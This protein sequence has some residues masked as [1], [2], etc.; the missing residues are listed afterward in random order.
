MT[1][2][3]IEVNEAYRHLFETETRFNVIYGGAGSGKSWAIAQMIILSMLQGNPVRKWLVCRKVGQTIRLSVWPQLLAIIN[4]LGL[5]KLFAYNKTD[6]TITGPGGGE[7]LCVGLDDV[8]KLKSILGVT[9][10]WVE[11]ASE[12][13]PADFEEL[14]TR[15]RGDRPANYRKKIFLSFNPINKTHWIKSYFFDREYPDCYILKTTYKD[16]AFLT[17]DDKQALLKYKETNPY[18]Y[19]VYALGEW[20][21]IGN[22]IFSNYREWAF[23][24]PPGEMLWG[25]DFGF[26]HPS[27]I[28]GCKYHDG[29]LWICREFCRTGLT[30]S[31]LVQSAESMKIDGTII[32]DAAEPDRIEEF[33]RS[34][35]DCRQAAKGQ[36]SLV[37][38]IDWLQSVRINI[39]SSCPNTMSEI[40]GYK[41]LEDKD[42]KSI[43]KPIP[44]ND[45]CLA[46]IRYAVEPVRLAA[47]PAEAMENPWR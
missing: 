23:D 35:F 22:T 3:R 43:D 21:D 4:D 11:E 2:A 41:W 30:N 20:G 7:I 40:S 5:Y 6:R 44:Y 47:G 25:M 12:L 42:G 15:I 29:E 26:N 8:Q 13:I 37:A 31:D 46:A 38:G 9:D 39:H 33:R 17:D 14:D 27:T 34:G 45:D 24:E 1:T 36:G 18:R 16:N 32:A 28:I 19:Q 10:I